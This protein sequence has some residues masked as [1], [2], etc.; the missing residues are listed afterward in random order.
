MNAAQRIVRHD[1][2]C[3][4]L[5]DCPQAQPCALGARER[6]DD[7]TGGKARA[8]QQNEID[9]LRLQD[10]AGLERVVL[11]D[12][13]FLVYIQIK[14]PLLSQRLQPLHACVDGTFFIAGEGELRCAD[15]ADF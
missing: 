13:R 1:A 4:H 5:R 8:L 9:G 10:L 14:I 2:A 11:G 7:Q 15:I 12:D 3:T 6:A